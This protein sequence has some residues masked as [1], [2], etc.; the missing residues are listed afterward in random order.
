MMRA[1]A[2]PKRDLR[3]LPFFTLSVIAMAMARD[4]DDGDEDKRPLLED[5]FEAIRR[6]K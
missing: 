6:P 4:I 5:V 1:A 3:S 2:I